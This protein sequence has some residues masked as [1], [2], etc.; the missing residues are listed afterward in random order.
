MY[1]PLTKNQ[2]PAAGTD[3][4]RLGKIDVNYC[5]LTGISLETKTAPCLVSLL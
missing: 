4:L 3:L 5:Q 1:A 2:A